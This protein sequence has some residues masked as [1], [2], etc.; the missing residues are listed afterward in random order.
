MHWQGDSG[1]VDHDGLGSKCQEQPLQLAALPR[2][3][4]FDGMGAVS[5]EGVEA[6]GLAVGA[7]ATVAVIKRVALD[8]KRNHPAIALDRHRPAIAMSPSLF[9]RTAHGADTQGD[10]FQDL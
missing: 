7:Y 6:I 4:Q 9:A 10:V 1:P 3:Q 5:L 8:V 2:A